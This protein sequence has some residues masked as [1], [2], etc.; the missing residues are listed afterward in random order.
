MFQGIFY[1]LKFKDDFS[2][3]FEGASIEWQR[4][5]DLL[6]GTDLCDKY[7]KYITS[8]QFTINK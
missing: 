8:N 5:L 1:R 7:I 4:E 2:I 3:D 6:C